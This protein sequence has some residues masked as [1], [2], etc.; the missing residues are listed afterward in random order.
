MVF[1]RIL[2][3]FAGIVWVGAVVFL[4]L[5]VGPAAARTGKDSTPFIL[6]MFGYSVLNR[7]LAIA[8]FLTTLAGLAL[9]ERV[10][11]TFDADWMSTSRGIVL[12]IGS[13]AGLLAFGH[14]FAL[15]RYGGRMQTI[16]RDILGTQG[17][18]S[19][20]QMISIQQIQQKLRVNGVISMGLLIIAV[21]GMS[22]A[23]YV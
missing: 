12:S 14:G 13:L 3:I 6:N 10:S 22:A 8:A 1:F 5:V 11:N 16:A 18:P 2:H 17:P 7:M 23:R 21:F 15:S 4:A 9:Y 19:P 20:E